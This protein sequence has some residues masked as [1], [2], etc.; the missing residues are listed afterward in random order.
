[1]RGIRIIAT[2]SAL[3]SQIVTN[4][5][6]SKIVET[7]DEWIVK[8]T[9]IRERRK[10]VTESHL[11]LAAGA[12]AQALERAGIDREKIG[13]CVVATAAADFLTPSCAALLQAALNLPETTP[14]FD[15]SAACS[16]FLYALRVTQGMLSD[17]KPYGI[18]IGC[19]TLSRLTDYTDRGTCV[20]FGDGAG[21]VIVESA[22]DAPDIC[23]DLGA[24]TNPEVLYINGATDE[25]PSHI[26]MLGTDVFKFAVGIIPKSISRVLERARVDISDVDYFVLHQANE[27]IIDHVMKKME[28][29][30]E[31]VFKNI[32]HY[33]NMSAACIPIGIDDLYTAG[34]LQQGMRLMCVGFGGGLTW[35]G[36]LI[37]IG[38]IR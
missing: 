7:S 10:C 8:R 29:P 17:E 4:D 20:L 34:R 5:D 18:V 32:A 21:A 24:R 31:K 22:E 28:L 26:H 25:A 3:P 9:G 19:E 11:D 16:G 37:T 1:M 14:C 2:G 38:G 13:V 27:R 23:A 35:G 33:G 30:E 12:A 6:L 15:I 36:G